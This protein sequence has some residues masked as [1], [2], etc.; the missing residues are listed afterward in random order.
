MDVSFAAARA[1]GAG[2]APRFPGGV[3]PASLAEGGPPAPGRTDGRA[4]RRAHPVDHGGRRLERGLGPARLWVRRRGRA[5]RAPGGLAPGGGAGKEGRGEVS[6]QECA[7]EL[8]SYLPA[9]PKA[10]AIIYSPFRCAASPFEL[11]IQTPPEG[12]E[13]RELGEAAV[14]DAPTAPVPAG[15][16]HAAPHGRRTRA[17]TLQNST[18]K[19]KPPL[20]P[21][22]RTPRP[23]RLSALKGP[24]ETRLVSA[25]RGRA[26]RGHR[27][28]RAGQGGAEGELL[29]GGTGQPSHWVFP[30]PA[31]AS[32]RRLLALGGGGEKS[33]LCALVLSVWM[34]RCACEEAP[35]WGFLCS[36]L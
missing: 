23:P 15:G 20:S 14:P 10:K 6:V 28:G 4:A 22:R 25:H 31:S 5:W 8:C 16:E 11:D 34:L 21:P 12:R 2:P 27:L 30:P 32:P 36:R 19:H 3:G 33:E 17:P 7:S 26:Q 9:F 18:Q 1:P 24:A 13:E 35:G 29:T